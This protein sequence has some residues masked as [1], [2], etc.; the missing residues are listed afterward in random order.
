MSEVVV[1]QGEDARLHEMSRKYF[2]V[3]QELRASQARAQRLAIENGKLMQR[4]RNLE[5]LVRRLT[6]RLAREVPT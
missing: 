3:K 6:N 1:G 2:E 4:Q 5:D